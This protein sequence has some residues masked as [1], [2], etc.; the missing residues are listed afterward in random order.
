MTLSGEGHERASGSERRKVM[1]VIDGKGRTRTASDVRAWRSDYIISVHVPA[2]LT[3]AEDGTLT[4]SPSRLNA[5]IEQQAYLSPAQFALSLVPRVP[6]PTTSEEQ[7]NT[8]FLNRSLKL[9][10]SFPC[11]E[12]AYQLATW[13]SDKLSTSFDEV[14]SSKATDRS[15]QIGQLWTG[16]TLG[17]KL[18]LREQ[19]RRKCDGERGHAAGETHEVEEEGYERSHLGNIRYRITSTPPPLLDSIFNPATHSPSHLH[20]YEASY[21]D[22]MSTANVFEI[23][24][25][26]T[27]AYS[28]S[29]RSAP[30]QYATLPGVDRDA[31]GASERADVSSAAGSDLQSSLILSFEAGPKPSEVSL[32]L[33][34]PSYGTAQYKISP[35]PSTYTPPP[36]ILTIYPSMWYCP[37]AHTPCSYPNPLSPS[38]ETSYLDQMFMNA[39]EATY[40]QADPKD[41]IV[42]R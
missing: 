12:N 16:T 42:F 18:R 4:D 23:Q 21:L 40:F 6:S 28:Q 33:M 24:H 13:T 37:K 35:C 17:T 8:H 26:F 22:Q 9:P 34:I 15:R 36:L 32:G 31:H 3:N 39:T 2:P 1:T 10:S 29:T 20:A 7:T 5:T 14:H 38:Y 11:A 19:R 30:A 27:F 41:D 25:V